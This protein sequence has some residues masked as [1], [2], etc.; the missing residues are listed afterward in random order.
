[1]RLTLTR[2][3]Q[4]AAIRGARVRVWI[5]ETEEGFPVAAFSPRPFAGGGGVAL[6]LTPTRERACRSG[7]AARVWHA[8]PADRAAPLE[9][10]VVYPAGEM[11]PAALLGELAEL[12]LERAETVRIDPATL[13]RAIRFAKGGPGEEAEP[14]PGP[15]DVEVVKAAGAGADSPGYVYILDRDG[16]RIATVFGRSDEKLATAALLARAADAPAEPAP[17]PRRPGSAP[18]L[19]PRR[20]RTFSSM[21]ARTT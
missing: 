3:D 6:R 2:T 14:A 21:G 19:L 9:F 5:G 1:M 13:A 10:A 15:Y 8:D 17:Q 16:R 7:I 12:S 4:F 20:P 11:A 18:K